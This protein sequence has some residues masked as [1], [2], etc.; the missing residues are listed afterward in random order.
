MGVRW[1]LWLTTFIG[2]ATFSDS[3]GRS[4]GLAVTYQRNRLVA[5]TRIQLGSSSETCAS[6]DCGPDFGEVA[7]L[8]GYGTRA[9][10]SFHASVATGISTTGW[11][12]KGGVG[13]PLEVQ[14][15]WRPTEFVG[16]G[17]YGWATSA[18]PAFGVAFAVHLGR[19]R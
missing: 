10:G 12:N 4:G 7:L 3:S 9:G 1:G 5:S 16:A 19:L 13:V 2:P 8:V 14:L 11:Y 18:G 15:N 17:L 6:S